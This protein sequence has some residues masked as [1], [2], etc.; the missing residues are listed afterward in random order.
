MATLDHPAN[1]STCFDALC[2]ERASG[3]ISPS[4]SLWLDAHLQGCARCRNAVKE[5]EVVFGHARLPEPTDE[6]RAALTFLPGRIRV[7]LEEKRVRWAGWRPLALGL[8]AAV[9]LVFVLR[10]V[11]LRQL[12][13]GDA[14]PATAATAANAAAWEDPDVDALLARV[15]RDRP[16]LAVAASVAALDDAQVRAELIADAAFERAWAEE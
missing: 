6:E 16:D 7:A 9:A 12:R 13:S 2:A 1:G 15:E 10:P 14:A 4:D 11:A 5:Y 8:A 3:A